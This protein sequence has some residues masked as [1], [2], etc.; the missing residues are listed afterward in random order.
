MTLSHTFWAAWL[1]LCILCMKFLNLSVRSV[2]FGQ[3]GLWILSMKFV[4]RPSY[5]Q[6][7]V[8]NHWTSVKRSH[9]IASKSGQYDLADVVTTDHL[10]QSYQSIKCTSICCF[11]HR[12]VTLVAITVG[13]IF[14]SY[15]KGCLRGKN[16]IQVVY[17]QCYS[18]KNQSLGVS[19]YMNSALVTCNKLNPRG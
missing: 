4:P 1:S 11:N 17:Q 2:H 10:R 15:R 6:F 13:W 7:A 18:C 14:F 5:N 12:M 3:C 19:K 8:S 16:S 9:M